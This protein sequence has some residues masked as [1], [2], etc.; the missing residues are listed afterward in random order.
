MAINKLESFSENNV[1]SETD[2]QWNYK[3]A[4]I[5]IT[6]WRVVGSKIFK[7]SQFRPE[8]RGCEEQQDCDE[9]GAS[10]DKTLEKENREG[11]YQQVDDFDYS[12][13]PAPLFHAIDLTEPKNM[14][15][16]VSR[17]LEKM[18][19]KVF[20]SDTKKYVCRNTGFEPSQLVGYTLFIIE[21]ESKRL[22]IGFTT[23]GIDAGVYV[24]LE[25]DRG[26]DCGKVKS[27]TSLEKYMNLLDVYSLNNEIV[28][29]RILRT[30]HS[31]DLRMLA[32]KKELENEA[33][34][35]CVSKNYLDMEVVSCEYQWDMKKLTF[36]F[37]SDDR[38]DFRDLVKDLYKT[39][40]TRIW[41]CCVEKSKNWC[42]K[43]LMGGQA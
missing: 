24:I 23:E 38:V 21:F 5:E 22:D 11:Y 29:K 43:T 41:M 30:A 35:Y 15:C 34:R 13:P 19:R 2:E 3:E 40:K 16:K 42:L 31:E 28:P 12:E 20:T 33:L 14:Q 4:C 9:P 1:W 37:I 25:A 36:F 18:S 39:Y 6:D 7:A 32:K 10:L 26:E 17:T 8:R 27:L